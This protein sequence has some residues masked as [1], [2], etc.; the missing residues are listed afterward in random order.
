MDLKTVA[1][2]FGARAS[3]FLLKDMVGKGAYGTA[4]KVEERGKGSIK[5]LKKIDVSALAR[6]KRSSS[7][8][9][10]NEKCIPYQSKLF[11]EYVRAK[12]LSSGCCRFVETEDAWYEPPIFR[13]VMEYCPKGTL[14]EPWEE[15]LEQLNESEIVV[16]EDR[17]E[18]P[19][20]LRGGL[21][22]LFGDVVPL[23]KIFDQTLE[24]LVFLEKRDIAHLDLKPENIFIDANG[25]LKIGDFGLCKSVV[26][27]KGAVSTINGT[28]YGTEGFMAP[29]IL[30][31]LPVT[32]KADVYSFGVIIYICV[33]LRAAEKTD[34]LPLRINERLWPI[35]GV[36]A[37]LAQRMLAEVPAS[38]PSASEIQ[39]M[40][41][42][43]A[44][45]CPFYAPDLLLTTAT[46]SS[47]DS[48]LMPLRYAFLG[49]VRRHAHER[50]E[51]DFSRLFRS[52][53]ST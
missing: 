41:T 47:R 32:S 3:V 48:L 8:D 26:A 38:R 49:C 51:Y 29:E 45:P 31:Q 40:L 24:A 10:I 18:N 22:D 6:C 7:A 33:M 19:F 1:E 20:V 53:W 2:I 39:I 13:L 5:V 50:R 52:A 21:S 4:Y 46:Y 43:S 9:E 30:K 42:V 11:E 25:D 35:N 17:N 27:K 23:E 36:R 15:V 34:P 37:S 12:D 44:H 28:S 14:N 16:R